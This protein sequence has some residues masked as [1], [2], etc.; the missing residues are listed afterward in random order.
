MKEKSC[1]KVPRGGRVG[2]AAR[3]FDINHQIN[4]G[5]ALLSGD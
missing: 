3:P 5:E 1:E 2:L 4:S